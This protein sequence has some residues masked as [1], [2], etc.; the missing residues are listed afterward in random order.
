MVELFFPILLT[1]LNWTD[2]VEGEHDHMTCF[3]QWK[4]LRTSMY[5]F[6]VEACKRKS[7]INYISFPTMTTMFQ[8]KGDLLAYIPN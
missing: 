1:E 6:Q 5:H 8:T 4:V 2:P 7:A 3:D